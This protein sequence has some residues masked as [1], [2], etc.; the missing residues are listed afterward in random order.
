MRVAT[1]GKHFV[2]M[3]ASCGLHLIGFLETFM[4]VQAWPCSV[5]GVFLSGLKVGGGIVAGLMGHL[6]GRRG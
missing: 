5:N 1:E 2:A 3:Y 6:G 4:S